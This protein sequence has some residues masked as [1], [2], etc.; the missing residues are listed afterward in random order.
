MPWLW[1]FLRLRAR[2][3]LV[4]RRRLTLCRVWWGACRQLCSP[5]GTKGSCHCPGDSRGCRGERVPTSQ[6][7]P[8]CWCWDQ[9]LVSR[10]SSFSF[11]AHPAWGV[12]CSGAEELRCSRP[13]ILL[14]GC[15][16]I[17]ASGRAQTPFAA[18]AELKVA[19]GH[20]L[21]WRRGCKTLQLRSC[22]DAGHSVGA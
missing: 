11:A 21:R 16:A 22:S 9:H 18:A 13:C 2:L 7:P 12:P 3:V 1:V 8:V 20:E 6:P 19:L 10:D 17:A 4:L 5:S 14:L 15:T